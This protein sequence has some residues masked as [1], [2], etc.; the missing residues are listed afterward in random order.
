MANLIQSLMRIDPTQGLIEYV[1][2]VKPYHTKL[3]DILVEYVYTDAVNV[4]VKDNLTW[5]IELARPDTDVVYSCGYGLVWDQQVTS[6]TTIKAPIISALADS[7]PGNSFLIIPQVGQSYGIC[8]VNSTASLFSF[9]DTFNIVSVNYQSQQWVVSGDV[10]TLLF[11]GKAVYVNNNGTSVANGKY[12]VSSSSLVGSNTVVTVQ[13]TI[14]P[15]AQNNGQFNIPVSSDRFPAWI[16]GTQINLVSTGSLPTPLTAETVCFFAPTTTPGVFNLSTKAYPT[17]YDD[18][19]KVTDTGSGNISAFRSQTFFPGATVTVTS[20]F[21]TAN[22]GQYTI[23][24]TEPEGDNLRI[25]VR[26][27][28]AFSSP[29]GH[30]TDGMM[31]Y[32]INGYDAPAYCELAQAPDLYVGAYISE[33]LTFE[34]LINFTDTITSSISEFNMSGYG[35]MPFSTASDS[36]FGES[37]DSSIEANPLMA[38][39]TMLPHGIDAQMFDVGGIDESISTNQD[40]NKTI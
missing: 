22:N 38:G 27:K 5:V 36:L 24:K 40:M 34:Y 9:A 7:A 35:D 25:Y 6:E 15:L 30:A 16:A 12:I 39:Y 13:E 18:F 10:T 3:L 14:Y 20:S 23:M 31:I 21:H 26:E 11:A 1:N 2:T 37:T 33:M 32:N 17:K 4:T 8:V 28:V 29:I 19:V